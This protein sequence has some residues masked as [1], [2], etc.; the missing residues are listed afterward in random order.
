MAITSGSQLTGAAKQALNYVRT[1]AR[2]TVLAGWFTLFDVAGS[3]GSGVL[4][5]TSTTTGV[6]PDDTVAGFPTINTFGGGN[7]GYLSQVD[8]GNSVASRIKLYDL[9]WKAG[10]YAFNASTTGQTPTSYAARVP[11][12]DYTDCEIWLEQVT[13]GTGVQS[14][15]VTYT[16]EAGTTGRTT[17][18][19]VTGTNTIGRMFRLPF[20]AGDKG[21]QG[22]TG[23]VGSVATA[24][25]FNI[26]V[27]RPLWTGRVRA[28]NDGDI[29]GPDKTMMRQVYDTSA[30]YP[31]IASDSTISG[32]YELELTIAN[33]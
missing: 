27:M 26:L 17:G 14:V 2:T 16:N 11:N 21:V 32:V 28:A 8:F 25:T 12:A 10:A 22:I 1:G 23:V 24:G 13:A 29:H 7:I 6:V 15:A 3:P 20:Q 5:G 30:I 19:V 4:A 31:I 18:V 9:L 33:G